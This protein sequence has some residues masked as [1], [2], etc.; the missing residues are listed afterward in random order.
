M[1]RTIKTLTTTQ[2]EAAFTSAIRDLVGGTYSVTVDELN[3]DAR[4]WSERR[5]IT[6]MRIVIR[7]DTPADE[8]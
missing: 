5:D 6:D 4:A 1:T 7:R 8:N 3:F 2:L